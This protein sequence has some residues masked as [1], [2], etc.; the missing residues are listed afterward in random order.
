KNERVYAIIGILA[1]EIYQRMKKEG[2]IKLR[3]E[4]L[5]KVTKSFIQKSKLYLDFLKSESWEYTKKILCDILE[6][7]DSRKLSEA[8]GKSIDSLMGLFFGSLP[9]MIAGFIVYACS[10]D[11][12]IEEA[13][14]KAGFDLE[15]MST[16]IIRMEPK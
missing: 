3:P 7:V 15:S 2:I 14:E 10:V 8:T 13:A 9:K 11:P 12:E 1:E 16:T 5:Q 6:N 4:E